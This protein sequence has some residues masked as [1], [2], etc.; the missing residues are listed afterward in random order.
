MN[1]LAAI[2]FGLG[3]LCLSAC[4]S[5]DS[6]ESSAQDGEEEQVGT[7]QSA[8]VQVGNKTITSLCVS[9]SDK[10][11]AET[12]HAIELNF[13]TISNDFWSCTI[14][15]GAD[16]GETA[17]CTPTRTWKNNTG[18][19]LEYFYVQ[20]QSSSSTDG[21]RVGGISAYADNGTTINYGTFAKSSTSHMSFHDCNILQ[22]CASFTIDADGS[23]SCWKSKMSLDVA[24]LANAYCID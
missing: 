7:A 6:D 23:P 21:L 12:T 4:V 10:T 20:F 9:V 13:L 1:K 15:D 19:G 22:E 3:S 17:C 18:E 14:P 5:Y 11:N 16:R 2:L 8:V 24:G